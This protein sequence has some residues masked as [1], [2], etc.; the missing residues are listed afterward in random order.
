MNIAVNGDGV[1]RRVLEDARRELGCGRNKLTVLSTQIDPY[2]L[3]TAAG[4]RDGAWLAEQLDRSIGG[5][6]RIHWRGLH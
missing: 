4:H 1:L 2:R 5:E 3:D 6:Q